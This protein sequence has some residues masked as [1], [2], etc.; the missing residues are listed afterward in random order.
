M[1]FVRTPALRGSAYTRMPN[2]SHRVGQKRRSVI[3]CLLYD[4]MNKMTIIKRL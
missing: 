2:S 3:F 1:L 4:C